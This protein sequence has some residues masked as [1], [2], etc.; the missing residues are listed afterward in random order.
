[1]SSNWTAK[2]QDWEVSWSDASPYLTGPSEIVVEIISELFKGDGVLVTPTG[3]TLP[4]DVSS[5]EAVALIV[6][7]LHPEA[8]FDSFPDLVPLW[9]Q[10]LPEDAVF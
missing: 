2:V 4:A 5:S 3:P 8:S 7:R 6:A 10:N 9:D 1:V